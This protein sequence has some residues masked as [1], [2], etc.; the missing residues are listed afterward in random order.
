MKFNQR[1]DVWYLIPFYQVLQSH[2]I[3]HHIHF[4]KSLKSQGLIPTQNHRHNLHLLMKSSFWGLIL[5]SIAKMF[6]LKIFK[7]VC[8]KRILV[9]EI[10]L[11]NEMTFQV[12]LCFLPFHL[13]MKITLLLFRDLQYLLKFTFD[14]QSFDHRFHQFSLIQC[15]QNPHMSSPTF[16]FNILNFQIFPFV[17]RNFQICFKE[18]RSLF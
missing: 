18:I 7:T 9:V 3:L 6:G 8:L 4:L 10:L 5:I 16:T 15:V 13:L 14:I 17:M 1:D 11:M 12:D 2:R